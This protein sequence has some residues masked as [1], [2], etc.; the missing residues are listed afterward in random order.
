M[1]EEQVIRKKVNLSDT[2]FNDSE[3]SD[4][5]D[6]LLEHRGALFSC[7]E[8]LA[9]HGREIDFEWRTLNLFTPLH[10]KPEPE[11]L[12]GEGDR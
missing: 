10:F 9:C 4:F 1:I 6:V 11:N 2:I 8:L 7:N 12:C 3:K 5:Y